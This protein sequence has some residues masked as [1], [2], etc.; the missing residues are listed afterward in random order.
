MPAD[1]RQQLQNVAA[2]EDAEGCRCHPC[3]TQ[4]WHA[5]GSGNR[6]RASCTGEEGARTRP[7]TQW[8]YWAGNV[9]TLM[10]DVPDRTRAFELAA[11]A[12]Q[13]DS[14]PGKSAGHRP[15]NAP[16]RPPC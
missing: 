13:N 6:S 15:W 9:L 3:R 14:E 10:R 11:N 16:N 1:V 7:G 5:F 2:V 4:G 8:H 12:G